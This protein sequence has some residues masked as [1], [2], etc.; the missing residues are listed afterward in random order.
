MGVTVGG[1]GFPS[2]VLSCSTAASNDSNFATRHRS[3]VHSISPPVAGAG[4]AGCSALARGVDGWGSAVGCCAGGAGG[5]TTAMA[6]AGA[7]LHA[8]SRMIL[9]AVWNAATAAG[10]SWAFSRTAG[11]SGALALRVAE[12]AETGRSCSSLFNSISWACFLSIS[13]CWCVG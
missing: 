4:V 9:P 5:G 7:G 3:H 6:P 10:P 2:Q 13:L 8:S 1:G 12:A 11:Q